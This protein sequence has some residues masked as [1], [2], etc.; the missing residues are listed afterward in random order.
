M[1]YLSALKLATFLAFSDALLHWLPS[2]CV[3]H[4]FTNKFLFVGFL[5]YLFWCHGNAAVPQDSALVLTWIRS[6]WPNIFTSVTASIIYC[7]KLP[8]FS[9][10][11]CLPSSMLAHCFRLIPGSYT[12]FRFIMSQTEVLLSPL[13]SLAP[14]TLFP[15]LLGLFT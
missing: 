14:Q 2:N 15:V 1:L 11:L 7:R 12:H 13:P 4:C 3:G 10:Q 8:N 5:P 9:F 6:I